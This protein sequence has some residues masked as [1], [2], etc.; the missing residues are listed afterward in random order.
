VC[1]QGVCKSCNGYT[2]RYPRGN[3]TSHSSYELALET[4]TTS[5]S[6]TKNTDHRLLSIS[7]STEDSVEVRRRSDASE[8][9]DEEAQWPVRVILN[10]TRR[11]DPNDSGESDVYNAAFNADRINVSDHI[12][13]SGKPI[14]TRA[15]L[16]EAVSTETR[17]GQKDAM[18][19]KGKKRDR[20]TGETMRVQSCEDWELIEDF[21]E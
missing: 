20:F 6:G 5:N 17:K 16:D 9:E 11:F 13:S 21:G 4:N 8:T 15:L 7:K 2:M 10:E 14:K 19:S 3:L 1:L 18:S 12:S